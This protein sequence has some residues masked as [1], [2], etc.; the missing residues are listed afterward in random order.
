MEPVNAK[1]G[2]RA[3]FEARFDTPPD[4]GD[5]WGHRWRASQ[6]LR[7]DRTL[8]IVRR[9]QSEGGLDVLDVG[10]GL[11]EF[12]AAMA[13]VHST[14]RVV[15]VEL[16]E[17]AVNLARETNAGVDFRVGALPDLPVPDAAFD[18]VTALEVLYYLDGAD[19]RAAVRELRRVLRPGGHL[20][21]SSALDDGRRYF[22][23]SGAVALLEPAFVVEEVRTL[24][25]RLYG[26]LE[27]PF[28]KLRTKLRRVADAT[29]PIGGIA[30]FCRRSIKV[31][32][33]FET[34]AWFLERLARLLPGR[35]GRS[36]VMIVARKEDDGVA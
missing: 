23:E 17:A 22:T 30:R 14:N 7:H 33:G 28:L 9:L 26:V 19:R 5:A 4:E 8:E 36:H 13:A 29:G 16:S 1:W 6:R 32:L 31:I 24:H 15:G 10:C 11:G 20:A 18:L 2:S 3:W 35:P 21:F 27:R 25:G 12:S 34:P